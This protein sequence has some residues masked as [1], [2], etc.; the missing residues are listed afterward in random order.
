MQDLNKEASRFKNELWMGVRDLS[1]KTDLIVLVH[2]L[3]HKIPWY[4]QSNEST[5]QPALTFLLDEAKAL[6]IPWVLAITNKFSVSAHQQ[7]PTVEAVLQAYQAT[8]ST[9]EVVNSCPYVMPTA[10]SNLQP[11]DEGSTDSDAWMGA[12]KLISAPMNLVKRSFQ[13]KSTT[14]PVEGISAL[15]QLVH[16]VLRN[17]EEVALQVNFTMGDVIITTFRKGRPYF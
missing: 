4:T 11:V 15:C 6:G 12:H 17:Q 7:K 8:P 10:A 16:R 3:S 1:T 9:T 5:R 13:K 14:L 2:N